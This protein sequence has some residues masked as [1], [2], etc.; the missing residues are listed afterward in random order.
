MSYLKRQKMP[1]NWPVKRKGTAY[2]VS[3]NFSTNNGI[4]VLVALRDVLEIAQTRKEVKRAIHEKNI[5][6]NNKEVRDEKN[7]V[8]LFDVLTIIPLKKS[9]RLVLSEKGKFKLEEIK[10][11]EAGKKVSKVI[12]K[13]ILRGKKTQLNLSD[14]INFLSDVKCKTNDSVV[15]NFKDR[16]IENCLP[17]QEKANVVVFSGK[18]AGEKG[19]INKIEEG[20]KS[21]EVDVE[22]KKV[23]ILIKQ[24][25]VVEK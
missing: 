13:K 23:N 22:G 16:K 24:L 1:K 4:P 21:I 12:N 3:P 20:N 17:L 6:L 5:L 7:N 18:H 14:G 9:Y 25:M 8:L 11:S 15:I 19:T 10:D 2:V